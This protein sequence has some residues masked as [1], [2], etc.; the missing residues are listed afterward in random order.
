MVLPKLRIDDKGR[1]K[2]VP[3]ISDDFINIISVIPSSGL[4]DGVDTNFKIAVEYNL[5]SSKERLL[6]I[7]FNNQEAVNSF[8][9]VK[10]THFLVYRGNGKYEFNV[11]VKPK[12]WGSKEDFLVIVFLDEIPQ[13]SNRFLATD[14]KILTFK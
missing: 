1:F 12:N 5:F 3:P 6:Q 4:I 10:D 14:V 7:G 13:V 2:I 8:R 11:T 9:N